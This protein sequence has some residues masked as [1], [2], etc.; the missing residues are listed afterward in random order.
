MPSDPH[1][2]N[3]DLHYGTRTH[4][5]DVETLE[6][7]GDEDWMAEAVIEQTSSEIA[8]G[9]NPESSAD[10]GS[11][12]AD[13]MEEETRVDEAQEYNEVIDEDM[14]RESADF[15]ALAFER[16][17][18]ARKVK[19]YPSEVWYASLVDFYHWSPRQGRISA[20]KR[21]SRNLGRG[22]SFARGLR[23]QAR[24]FELHQ[25]LRP[26]LRGKRVISGSLLVN[27]DV[28]LGLQRW[29]RTLEV[30]TVSNFFM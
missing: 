25:A 2:P 19:H 24:Y 15:E 14:P 23:R 7:I 30:G 12:T 9:D 6:T 16:L 26:S 3:P 11:M 4:P 8:D 28:Y 10:E 17:R 5:I 18:Q 20:S 1:G 13:V 21:V 29:L 27:E 22:I